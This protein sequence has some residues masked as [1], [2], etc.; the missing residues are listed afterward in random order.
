[1]DHVEP[2]KRPLPAVGSTVWGTSLLILSLHQY[3]TLATNVYMW[4][5]CEDRVWVWDGRGRH[6]SLVKHP[7]TLLPSPS[8]HLAISVGHSERHV[9]GH[10]KQQRLLL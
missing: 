4:F 2:P 8:T 1:M 7:L 3:G 9:G 6:Y 10:E 5:K